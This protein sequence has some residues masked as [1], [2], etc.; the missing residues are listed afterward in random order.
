V[1]KKR[2]IGIL[3]VLSLMFS[4]SGCGGGGGEQ[5]D[6]VDPGETKPVELKFAVMHGPTH[7][8]VKQIL[9]PW[10]QEVEKATEGRVK[11]TIYPVDTLLK[12]NDI[13]EGVVSGIADIGTC[14]PGYNPGRFPMLSA[15][16]L[17]GLEYANSKVAS[18]VAWDLV[19][20]TEL[21]ETKDTKFMFVYGLQPSNIYSTTPIR[22]LEDLQGKQIRVT[23][24]AADSI[25]ALGGTPVGMPMPEAYEGLLKGTINANLAPAEVLL[26]WNQAEVTSTI[27]MTPF[28]N[29]VFH[30]ITMNLEVWNSLPEDIQE[31]IE[32]ANKKVFEQ[33]S[34]VFDEI[35]AE[36]LDYAV[37]E[38]GHEVIELSKEEKDK[39]K[40]RLEPLQEKWVKEME[41]KGLP[42]Q[43][44]LDR[45]KEACDKYNELY[46]EY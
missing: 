1:Q 29:T 2:I 43:E 6:A 44:V 15:F 3:L 26:G 36:G 42:A 9:E 5:K 30:Y 38:F 31:Q 41:S 37:N 10:V 19:K 12:S 39:W 11:I 25:K 46:T 34:T 27:T 21:D 4:L 20:E 8:V 33:T 45:V 23:G 35:C 24:F 17:G 32:G 22:K 13:Y 16:F 28:I 40:A 18:Y 14:D 7:A